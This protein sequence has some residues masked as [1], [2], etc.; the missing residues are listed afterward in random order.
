MHNRLSKS[1][2]IRGHSQERC[3]EGAL[4]DSIDSSSSSPRGSASASFISPCTTE[5]H[6]S[7]LTAIGSGDLIRAHCNPSFSSHP[8]PGLRVRVRVRVQGSGFRVR[9]MIQG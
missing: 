2:L 9:V 5:F 3:F 8:A 7:E 4:H 6:S 1:V